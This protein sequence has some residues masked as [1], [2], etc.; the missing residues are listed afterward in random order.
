MPESERFLGIGPPDLTGGGCW[1]IVR[2]YVGSFR[3]Q[4]SSCGCRP[5]PGCLTCRHHAWYEARAQGLRARAA[6]KGREP[7]PSP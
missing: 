7:N 1:V 5:R 6:A 3:P 2:R 4:G